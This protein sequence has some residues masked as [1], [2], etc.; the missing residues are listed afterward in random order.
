MALSYDPVDVLASFARRHGIA[1]P[2]LADVGSITIERLGLLNLHIA[3]QRAHE[4]K[5]VEPKHHRLPYPGTIVIDE[6]GAVADKWFEASHQVRPSG[7]ALL[8]ELSA[9][10]ALDPALADE[11]AA[12]GVR[13]AG[14][15]GTDRYR[16]MQ[17]QRLQVSIDIPDGLHLYGE[18]APPGF[19]PLGLAL[20]PTDSVL[21]HRQVELPAPRPFTMV[22]VDERFVVHEGRLDLELVFV[23]RPDAEDIEVALDVEF[24]ACDERLCHPPTTLQLR[25]ALTRIQDEL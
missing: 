21:L 22:G 17:L 20:G 9:A 18:P 1:Y 6:G 11:A 5:P 4:G 3:Q 15:L 13:V 16:P 14:W 7:S 10:T 23:V 8:A 2:L 25:F 24:Q 12:H 19:V